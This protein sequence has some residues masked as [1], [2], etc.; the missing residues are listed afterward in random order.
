MSGSLS[1]ASSLLEA[2]KVCVQCVLFISSKLLLNKHFNFFVPYIWQLAD[3]NPVLKNIKL[4]SKITSIWWKLIFKSLDFA[5]I[6]N[7]LLKTVIE[8]TWKWDRELM[9][10]VVPITTFKT[11]I[12]LGGKEKKSLTRNNFE[13]NSY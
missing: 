8:K 10:M 5:Q 13:N 11:A 9:V 1:L 2:S 12:Y 3:I 7:L 4:V 6:V